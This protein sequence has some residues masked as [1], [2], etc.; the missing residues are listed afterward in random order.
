MALPCH[1]PRPAPVLWVLGNLVRH[2]IERLALREPNRATVEI[3]GPAVV[4]MDALVSHLLQAT[5]DR[6]TVV[7]AADAPY[8]GAAISDDSLVAAPGALKGNIAFESWLQART[9]AAV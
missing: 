3:A 6:R 1:K 9:K 4:R 5:G 7:G 8:F 2:T